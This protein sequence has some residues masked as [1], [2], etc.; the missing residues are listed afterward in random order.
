[1]SPKENHMDK[2]MPLGA[3][4]KKPW[5]EVVKELVPKYLAGELNYADY[6]DDEDDEADEVGPDHVID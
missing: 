2:V 3:A 5:S 1:M 6:D 4:L